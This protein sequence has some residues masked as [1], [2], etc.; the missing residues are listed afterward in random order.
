MWI[1]IIVISTIIFLMLPVT[2]YLPREMEQ[3]S[4]QQSGGLR[5]PLG[6]PPPG[7]GTSAQRGLRRGN[8]VAILKNEG[9]LTGQIENPPPHLVIGSPREVEEAHQT[10]ILSRISK[11]RLSG[12]HFPYN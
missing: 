3:E 8:E 6:P 11:V 10:D 7:G 5:P 12:E 9:F 2:F 4:E 1:V